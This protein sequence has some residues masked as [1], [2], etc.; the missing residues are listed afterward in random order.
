[1]RKGNDGRIDNLGGLRRINLKLSELHKTSFVSSSYGIFGFSQSV[2]TVSDRNVWARYL[3]EEAANLSCCC[4][5]QQPVT[6]ILL[7]IFNCDGS[8]TV[9][10]YLFF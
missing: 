1:M 9:T 3:H 10:G 4:C 5:S 6:F 8:V 7:P 2:A